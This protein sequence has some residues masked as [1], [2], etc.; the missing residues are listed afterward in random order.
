[1]TYKSDQFICEFNPNVKAS[2]R[3]GEEYLQL[4]DL[5]VRVITSEA[6]KTDSDS[7]LSKCPTGLIFASEVRVYRNRKSAERW[8][9]QSSLASDSNEP[10]LS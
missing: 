5:N 1:M 7:F 4:L 2:R 3:S 6:G 8:T 9:D 10:A